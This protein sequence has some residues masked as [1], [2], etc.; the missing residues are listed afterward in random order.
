M[1]LRTCPP[2]LEPAGGGSLLRPLEVDYAA[3]LRGQHPAETHAPLCFL[4]LAADTLLLAVWRVPCNR[5]CGAP[6]DDTPCEPFAFVGV[7]LL[8]RS[9][10]PAAMVS[11]AAAAMAMAMETAVANVP[12]PP[13]SGSAV[14]RQLSGEMEYPAGCARC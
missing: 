5:L 8:L 14:R 6:C 13:P 7:S 11:A 1:R 2:A 12:S 10:R 3:L 9:C 4:E